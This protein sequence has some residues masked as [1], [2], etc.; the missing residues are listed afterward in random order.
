MSLGSRF[1]LKFNTQHLKL[2]ISV[3][4][5]ICLF[6]LLLNETVRISDSC[7]ITQNSYFD[8]LSSAKASANTQSSVFV[9]QHSTL[10]T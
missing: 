5:F 7:F 8:T 4:A 2:S 6:V 10:K 1:N 3:D 9:T